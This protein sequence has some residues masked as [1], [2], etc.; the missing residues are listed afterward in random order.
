M[1]KL[2][3]AIFSEC[4]GSRG[5]LFILV[6]LLLIP[7]RLLVIRGGLLLIL[8]SLRSFFCGLWFFLG[9]C[10]LVTSCCRQFVA[11]NTNS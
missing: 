2:P 6:G 8:G 10:D 4:K 7:G 11:I 3:L 1:P 9:G 5:L